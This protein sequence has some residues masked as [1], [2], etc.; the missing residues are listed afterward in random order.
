MRFFSRSMGDFRSQSARYAPSHF[1]GDLFSCSP[2]QLHRV[3]IPASFVGQ[4]I[5][6]YCSFILRLFLTIRFSNPSARFF[7]PRHIGGQI[8][9]G[10]VEFRGKT[11][12]LKDPDKF[13]L[14]LLRRTLEIYGK[15]RPHALNHK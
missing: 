7:W 14:F 11:T 6:L 1:C 12:K 4:L 3:N 5:I 2:L 13:G 15:L 8:F 10:P 9:P